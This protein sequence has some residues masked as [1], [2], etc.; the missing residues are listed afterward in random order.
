MDN[1]KCDIFLRHSVKGLSWKREIRRRICPV[2]GFYARKQLLQLSAR[3]SH[4]NSVCPSAC[5]SVIKVDQSKMVQARITK[6]LPSAAW[7]TH[8]SG[9]V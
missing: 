7:K 3:L 4:R 2:N 1:T 5:P 6:S 8:V 9:T